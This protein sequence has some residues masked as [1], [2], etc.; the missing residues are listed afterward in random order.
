MKFVP[1]YTKTI[2]VYSET[3]RQLDEIAPAEAVRPGCLAE[4]DPEAL[5]AGQYKAL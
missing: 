4:Y 3:G 2:P 1:F 5:S